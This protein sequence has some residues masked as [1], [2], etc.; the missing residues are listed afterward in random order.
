MNGTYHHASAS[1]FAF[2]FPVFH[3]PFCLLD[4]H[5]PHPLPFFGSNTCVI[6]HYMS[7]SVTMAKTVYYLINIIVKTQTS[8]PAS[9]IT[10][11]LNGMCPLGNISYF[12]LIFLL[13]RVS[14]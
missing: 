1:V 7:L 12:L 13:R 4:S 6:E 2:T 3:L 14:P 5:L 11:L 9:S 10:D 8:P